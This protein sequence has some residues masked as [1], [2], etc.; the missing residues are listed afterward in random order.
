MREDAIREAILRLP[1]TTFE[2]FA[3]EL[4]RR[5]LYPGLNPTS[6]TADLG[7]D[8]R[9][10]PSTIFLN[11]GQW[12]SVCA[13]KTATWKKIHDDCKRCQQTGRQIDIL[14]F[15]TAKETQ[16]KQEDKWRKQVR[17]LFGWELV[18]H[19]LRWFAPTASAPQHES[20]VDDYLHI[21]PPNG[22]FVQVI[23]T[24]LTR[25]TRQALEHISTRI[26]GIERS[27][28]RQEV[29]WIEDQLQQGKPV[30]LTGEAGTGK[31]GIGALLARDQQK[32]VVLLDAR[33]LGAIQSE[34]DLRRSLS[35]QGSVVD[36]F[37]R[38]ARYRGGLRLIVDQVDSIAGLPSAEVLIDVVAECGRHG[39]C[40]VVVLSRKRE[41]HERRLLDRLATSGFVELTSYPLSMEQSAD[42][43]QELGIYQPHE[44]LVVLGQNLLHL[45]IIGS[46][47]ARQ[48]DSSLSAVESD[49]DLWQQYIHV[50]LAKETV[51]VG[52]REAEK[53]IVAAGELARQGLNSSDR[54][55]RLR[56]PLPREHERLMSW[57]ILVHDGPAYRFRHDSLQDVL[58]ARDAVERRLMPRDILQEIPDYRTRLVFP[59]MEQLYARV[60]S[61]LHIRFLMETFGG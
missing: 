42:L 56:R 61:Q 45:D 19:A 10:E 12:V 60:D 1:G 34:S 35:L 36:A 30:M 5:T 51:G 17:Q 16:T 9:T 7:E 33:R 52:S 6:D 25:H 23:E 32:A 14:V 48:P 29:G 31:S 41:T 40:D 49:L 37:H 43:L 39:V 47:Q 59:L 38:L 27:L 44:R 4:L 22:D 20:L 18:V 46:I 28:P 8:A 13:S 2:H 21:P 53:I 54:S 15:A 50:L 58:Y 55:F 57:S 11:N 3:R 24:E 26:P